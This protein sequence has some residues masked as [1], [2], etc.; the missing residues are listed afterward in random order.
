MSCT[1]KIRLTACVALQN[2][3]YN[4]YPR[5][6]QWGCRTDVIAGGQGPNR[7]LLGNDKPE[8]TLVTPTLFQYYLPPL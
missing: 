2:T 7:R 6:D 4:I 8:L 5:I 3:Q 1:Q